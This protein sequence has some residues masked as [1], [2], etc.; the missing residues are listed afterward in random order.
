MDI[1]NPSSKQLSLVPETFTNGSGFTAG[2]ST[3]ITLANTY[4]YVNG[5]NFDASFQGDDT[6]TLSGNTLTFNAVIPVG[7]LKVYFHGWL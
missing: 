5:I 6:Y 4:T 1:V 7:V 2:T 3:S